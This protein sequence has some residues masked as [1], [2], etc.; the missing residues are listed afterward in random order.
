MDK[1]QICPRCDNYYQPLSSMGTWQCK[2]HPGTYDVDTGFSCCGKKVR[3][4]NYNPTYV[5]LGAREEYIR[6]PKGCTP[7]DCGTDL[8][9]IHIESIAQYVDTIDINKWQGFFY[10]MLHRA[11][12][13]FENR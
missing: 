11:K 10:P 5:M 3:E 9:P 4:I 6:D 8:K 2:Y 7:C 13:K 1:L 12:D